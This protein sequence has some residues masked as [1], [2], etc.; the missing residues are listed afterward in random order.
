[1][2]HA[3]AG[4]S[5][6][7]LTRHDGAHEHEEHTLQGGHVEHCFGGHIR[8]L[9][10]RGV[11]SWLE[12]TQ[13][14][15]WSVGQPG[16]PADRCRHTQT[17]RDERHRRRQTETDGDRRTDRQTGRQTDSFISL[18][19][20]GVCDMTAH[21]KANCAQTHRAFSASNVPSASLAHNERRPV[22]VSTGR[23]L[24]L[25]M[26]ASAHSLRHLPK[27]CERAS[28]VLTELSGA[29]LCWLSA[30]AVLN[31]PTDL[32]AGEDKLKRS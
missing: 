25:D 24:A 23:R 7:A 27:T 14:D 13:P 17:D 28:Q 21:C 15:S 30:P 8:I 10:G 12:D 11:C 4:P 2:Y 32:R 3:Q 18:S 31:Q 6:L 20:C 26:S 9:H 19:R 1:M 29:L 22:R 16:R 5:G